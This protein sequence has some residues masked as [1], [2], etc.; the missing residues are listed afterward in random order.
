MWFAIMK[1]EIAFLYAAMDLYAVDM[2]QTI[3]M[4]FNNLDPTERRSIVV[5]RVEHLPVL[6]LIMIQVGSF[7]ISSTFFIS[8]ARK[9]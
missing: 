5:A 7:M 2:D 6:S 4:G 1:R 9:S 3:I 8:C